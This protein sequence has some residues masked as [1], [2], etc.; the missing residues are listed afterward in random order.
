MN[1]YNIIFSELAEL[2]RLQEEI[3]AEIDAKKDEIKKAMEAAGVDSI[4]GAEHK[5]TFKTITT[6][7][8]D[9]TALKKELPE[10]AARYT[11]TTTTKRFNFI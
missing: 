3:N 11:V 5:A 2:L 7:R 10:I 1:N 9:S 4:T 8:V 6:A